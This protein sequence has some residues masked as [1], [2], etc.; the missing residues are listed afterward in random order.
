MAYFRSNNEAMDYIFGDFARA[1]DN[2]QKCS[3]DLFSYLMFPKGSINT[4]LPSNWVLQECSRL[5][6]WKLRLFYKH[7]SGGLLIDILGSEKEYLDGESLKESYSKL[8]FHRKCKIYSLKHKGNLTA[9]LVVNQ[10]NLGLN[11]SELLNGIT[12][13]VTDPEGLPWEVLSLAAGQ[14]ANVYHLDRIPL[15]IYPSDYLEVRNIPYD[16][17]YQLWL[18]DMRYTEKFL[19][20]MQRRFRTK[21]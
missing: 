1:L 15:L 9:V 16:K 14:L 11:L 17:Q 5:D 2:P 7:H 20:Y 18:G 19:G 10:S 12:A 4:E 3:L 21:I 6:F 13:I 8:G